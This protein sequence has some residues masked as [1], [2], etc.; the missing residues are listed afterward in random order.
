MAQSVREARR[1]LEG[2]LPGT[3][4]DTLYTAQLLTSELVTN[5]VLHA[6]TGIEVRAW[7]TNG[8]VH[9]RVFDEMATRLP[10]PH[11]QA[12]D[13]G[14]GRGLHMVEHLS[15]ACGIEVSPAGKTVWFELWPKPSDLKPGASWRAP[16][17]LSGQGVRV[18]L[19]D[20]P[21]GLSRAAQR[22]RDL[23]GVTL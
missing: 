5:A 1:F 8:S 6:G 13:A 3:D 21:V 17:P 11:E 14:T 16:R 15:A 18:S 10:I 23:H 12:P 2:A 22:H 4:R 9:V 19:V 20:V 7:E